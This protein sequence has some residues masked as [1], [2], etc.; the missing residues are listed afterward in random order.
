MFN[1]F[2]FWDEML[3]IYSGD[4][5]EEVDTSY[6]EFEVPRHLADEIAAKVANILVDNGYDPEDFYAG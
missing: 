4:L 1:P 5:P 6:L 2:K 3:E